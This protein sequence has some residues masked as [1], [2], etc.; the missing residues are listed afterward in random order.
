MLEFQ[1]PSDGQMGQFKAFLF[2][3]GGEGFEFLD[4]FF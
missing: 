4:G 1:D 3:D 2:S